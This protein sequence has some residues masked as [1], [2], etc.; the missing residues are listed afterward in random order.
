V[1]APSKRL[2]WFE[3]SAHTPQLDQPDKFRDVLLDV[4]R[5]HRRA[6]A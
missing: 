3:D 6:T 4:A 2:I 1:T 5:A